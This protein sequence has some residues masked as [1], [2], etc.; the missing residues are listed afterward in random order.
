MK[1]PW[2]ASSGLTGSIR[3]NFL[4]SWSEGAGQVLFPLLGSEEMRAADKDRS[5]TFAV[6]FGGSGCVAGDRKLT[7]E[8]IRKLSSR[9]KLSAEL[10][11][12]A[13]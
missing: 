12:A 1:Y 7:V 4:R 9:F 13:L 6:R 2:L 3:R 10:F 8:Q 5:E 11:I